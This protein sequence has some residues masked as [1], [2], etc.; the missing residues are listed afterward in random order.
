MSGYQEDRYREIREFYNLSYPGYGDLS[1]SPDNGK[2]AKGLTKWNEILGIAGTIPEPGLYRQL[3]QVPDEERMNLEEC[4]IAQRNSLLILHHNVTRQERE[5]RASWLAERANRKQKAE[6]HMEAQCSQLKDEDKL[7]REAERV[8]LTKLSEY[9]YEDISHSPGR[10]RLLRLSAGNQ[11]G[12]EVQIFSMTND[13][14]SRPV[15]SEPKEMTFPPP[16]YVPDPPDCMLKPHAFVTVTYAS[17]Y[18]TR[19]FGDGPIWWC[20]YKD[21]YG[22]RKSFKK[23]HDPRP[24]W[25]RQLTLEANPEGPRSEGD[26]KDLDRKCAELNESLTQW[27]RK[28]DKE[29]AALQKWRRDAIVGSLHAFNIDDP[30]CPHFEALSW[31]RGG[32][33]MMKIGRNLY[34]LLKIVQLY[35]EEI[36]VWADAVCINQSSP[37]ERGHQVKMMG[38]VYTKA[39]KVLAWVPVKNSEASIAALKLVPSVTSDAVTLN[40]TLNA[41]DNV[42]R[43][44][45][46]TR[47]WIIQEV[48]LARTLVILL[49]CREF[50]MQDLANTLGS[51]KQIHDRDPAR[52]SPLIRDILSLTVANLAT[53]RRDRSI[54]APITQQLSDLLLIYENNKCAVYQDHVYALYNLVGEHRT[55][56]QV[57]YTLK[58]H[59]WCEQVLTFLDVHEPSCRAKMIRLALALS[60]LSGQRDISC[61]PF[62][63]AQIGVKAFDRGGLQKLE[64]CAHSLF[65]RGRTDSL[66]PGIRWTLKETGHCLYIAK[67]DGD[68]TLHRVSKRVLSYFTIS[69][70]PFLRGLAAGHIED[71][72]RIWQFVD[73]KYAFVARPH[74]EPGDPAS[75]MKIVGRCYLFD[76]DP[77]AEEQGPWD[78]ILKAE[79]LGSR[80]RDLP[81]YDL[82]LNI[83]DMYRLAFS[84]DK[85]EPVKSPPNRP[86]S[87]QPLLALPVRPSGSSSQTVKKADL[88]T[89]L[90]NHGSNTIKKSQLQ[91]KPI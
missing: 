32:Y 47:K 20:R 61:Q 90:G 42:L 7:R 62:S 54:A 74:W 53:Y 26:E 91:R 5:W 35:E 50:A 29:D 88:L 66:H 49:G 39:D 15:I 80:K 28:L 33:R 31:A 27:L 8:R 87:S 24:E 25:E 52:S 3:H 83:S 10:F 64:D 71:G 82:R 23:F 72:D 86:A 9:S 67:K 56:L 37:Q 55:H 65:L 84:A 40:Q 79:S 16:P 43:A 89:T 45:Y 73:T 59:D 2:I 21:R 58:A 63:A 81:S 38:T 57:D 48:I 76:Y 77:R 41:L 30:D 36:W 70:A 12:P 6:A 78:A 44:D 4:A 51:L 60:R 68:D 11:P 85:Q 22:H 46:W 19:N 13:V 17:K 1:G 18:S 14:V 69:K 34:D 75:Y